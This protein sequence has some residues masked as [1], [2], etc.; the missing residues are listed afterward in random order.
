MIAVDSFSRHY[1]RCLEGIYDCT[2]RI[3]INAYFALGLLWVNLP[4]GFGHGGVD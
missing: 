4:V 3:V 2:D 1:E